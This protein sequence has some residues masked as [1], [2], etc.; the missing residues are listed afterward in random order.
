[1]RIAKSINSKAV[2]VKSANEFDM[3]NT[4]K[5]GLCKKMGVPLVESLPPGTVKAAAKTTVIISAAITVQDEAVSF[6]HF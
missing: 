2:E 4:M 5:D 6:I 1:M 3:T